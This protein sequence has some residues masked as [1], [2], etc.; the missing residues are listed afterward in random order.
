MNYDSHANSSVHEISDDDDDD[1]QSSRGSVRHVR[2]AKISSD[3]DDERP[4]SAA[5]AAGDCRSPNTP[6]SSTRS[7]L[8]ITP[9]PLFHVHE[10]KMIFSPQGGLPLMSFEPAEPVDDDT[11]T[12]VSELSLKEGPSATG[13]RRRRSSA[14]QPLMSLARDCISER[15]AFSS[16]NKCLF[17]SVQQLLV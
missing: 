15:G 10:E 7:P 9:R 14:L 11:P 13:R 6:C 1:Q 17:V 2:R 5:A 3:E 16:P 8:S 12:T 4:A